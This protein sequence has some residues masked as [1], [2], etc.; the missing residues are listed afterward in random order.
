MLYSPFFCQIT[1]YNNLKNPAVQVLIGRPSRLSPRIS[2]HQISTVQIHIMNIPTDEYGFPLGKKKEDSSV[3]N[4]RDPSARGHPP[5]EHT[6]HH[7]LPVYK[8]GKRGGTEIQGGG[9]R[10]FVR[11]GV[12]QTFVFGNSKNLLPPD[13]ETSQ[14]PSLKKEPPK[15]FTNMDLPPIVKRTEKNIINVDRPP[16]LKP[17]PKSR[18]IQ[19]PK[20]LDSI[21]MKRGTPSFSEAKIL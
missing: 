9:G 19:A 14:L 18:P 5:Q 21:S 11:A 10:S 17:S 4:R 8:E 2:P 12:S 13:K 6:V 16:T 7:F 15:T 20:N 3:R 1:E